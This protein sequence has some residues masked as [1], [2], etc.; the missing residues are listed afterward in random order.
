MEYYICRDKEKLRAYIEAS[1][2]SAA[3]V[4]RRAGFGRK[5]ISHLMTGRNRRLRRDY[6]ANVER[7]IG[8]YP[9]TI[10]LPEMSSEPLRP[11]S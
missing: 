4:A 3:E 5:Y 7:I 2:L 8:V 9:H 1:G 10:F 11:T 6:A